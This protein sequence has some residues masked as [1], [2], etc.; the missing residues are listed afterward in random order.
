MDDNV[1]RNSNNEASGSG[2]GVDQIN[3]FSDILEAGRLGEP[4]LPALMNYPHGDSG[5]FPFAIT[6]HIVGIAIG[7]RYMGF[8]I[9][10]TTTANVI[11]TMRR[12]GAV[13]E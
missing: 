11:L 9:G 7:L 8:S 3:A 13:W 10:W 1:Q 2:M 5:I 6:T 12:R 4:S